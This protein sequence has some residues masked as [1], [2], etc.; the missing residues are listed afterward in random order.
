MIS[1]CESQV[2]QY[3]E[4]CVC[5]ENGYPNFAGKSNDST[6]MACK[7]GTTYSYYPNNNVDLDGSDTTGAET[8][9]L[10]IG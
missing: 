8:Y 9:M 10:H 4:G 6:F 2:Y 3:I 7:V 1:G 5:V